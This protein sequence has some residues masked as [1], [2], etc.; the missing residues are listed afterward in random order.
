MATL[1][2]VQNIDRNTIADGDALQNI[3]ETLI[4]ND[5][6]LLAA[7]N[8]VNL[9]IE[10]CTEIVK[11]NSANWDSSLLHNFAT[12]V[13]SST[14]AVTALSG[15][16]NVS[17]TFSIHGSDNVSLT[18]NDN[19]TYGITT[20][21]QTVLSSYYEEARLNSDRVYDNEICLFRSSWINGL[22]QGSTVFY[23]QYINSVNGLCMSLAPDN[24]ETARSASDANIST[25][26]YKCDTF[27]STDLLGKTYIAQSAPTNGSILW[28]TDTYF[29][30]NSMS[31][32]MNSIALYTKASAYNRSIAFKGCAALNKSIAF[33]YAENGNSLPNYSISANNKSISLYTYANDNSIAFSQKNSAPEQTAANC[34]MQLLTS[35]TKAQINNSATVLM[36]YGNDC[37][38]D[39][40]MAVG[41]YFGSNSLSAVNKTLIVGSPTKSTADNITGYTLSNNSILIH[42]KQDDAGYAQYNS[43]LC[44]GMKGCAHFTPTESINTQYTDSILLQPSLHE[45]TYSNSL[46][47]GA[48]SEL[49]TITA[50]DAKHAVT[51]SI[52]FGCNSRYLTTA[53]NTSQRLNMPAFVVS[54]SAQNNI[55]LGATHYST[56]FTTQS[57][58][59]TLC[60]PDV[61]ITGTTTSI[62]AIKGRAYSPDTT[63]DISLIQSYAYANYAY[64]CVRSR[65]EQR[66]SIS[67]VNSYVNSATSVDD[68]NLY[69]IGLASAHTS[70]FKSLVLMN[71]AAEAAVYKINNV[72]TKI[73]PYSFAM[74]G[75]TAS[76]VNVEDDTRLALWKNTLVKKE[77]PIST[78]NKLEE[79]DSITALTNDTY[80]IITG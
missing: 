25:Y 1:D 8:N 17:S 22:S 43:S 49:D 64:T 23:G 15:A 11:T 59:L 35:L 10:Q 60:T 75:G 26:L 72:P 29:Y 76:Y 62:F 69:S 47:I 28:T 41:T 3:N 68:N 46:L 57:D 36:L 31:A 73:I 71:G 40:S 44:I 34:S 70:A 33:G 74:F 14:N 65:N 37:Y 5:E 39:N 13:L 24:S 77:F 66:H 27:T 16:S 58:T 45:Y 55:L 63:N 32:D 2:T 4:K 80:Y 48:I 52:I 54:N 79:I 53:D 30:G 61:S 18:Q 42:H 56:N 50:S 21:K 51:D 19:N 12:V 7:T 67:M 9:D 38:F 78:Y 20:L 6:T